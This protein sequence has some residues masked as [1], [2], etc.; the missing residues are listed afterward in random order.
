[1][2]SHIPYS[3]PV[4]LRAPRSSSDFGAFLRPTLKG[5]GDDDVELQVRRQAAEV[6]PPGSRFSQRA[7]GI[8]SVYTRTKKGCHIST[9]G[10][11]G[12]RSIP[13]SYM[14]PFGLVYNHQGSKNLKA[15]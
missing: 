1:M 4:S 13:Y 15:K 2:Y 5:R 14:D 10:P 6:L 3:P 12:P 7:P 11:L 8:S 9:L